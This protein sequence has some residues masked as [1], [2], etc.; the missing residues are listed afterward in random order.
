MGARVVDGVSLDDLL[1]RADQAFQ[2]RVLRRWLRASVVLN[3][4][5]AAAVAGLLVGFLSSEPEGA[6][7]S[8]APS[9]FSRQVK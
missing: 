9:I 7:P 3:F 2:C 1:N 5:L 8:S 6:H 4:L